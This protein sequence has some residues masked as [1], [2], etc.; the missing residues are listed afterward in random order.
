MTVEYIRRECLRCDV[1]FYTNSLFKRRCDRCNRLINKQNLPDIAK[2]ERI[3]TR[4]FLINEM[5]NK[6]KDGIK[7]MRQNN[8]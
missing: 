7:K 3:V 1:V 6:M 4:R 2:P 8:D 5:E